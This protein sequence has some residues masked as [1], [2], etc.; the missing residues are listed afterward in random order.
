M[1]FAFRDWVRDK[2]QSLAAYLI[3]RGQLEPDCKSALDALAA[4]YEKDI[5]Q[6]AE[7]AVVATLG[8]HDRVLAELEGNLDPDARSL[9]SLLTT[10]AFPADDPLCGS[11]VDASDA[12]KSYKPRACAQ[13]GGRFRILRFHAEGA[14]GAIYVARDEELNRDVA[15]KQIKDEPAYDP[16]A[17]VRFVR[18]AEITGRLEH[19]G[20]VPV[21]GLGEYADG[22]PEYAMRFIE[23][24]SLRTAIKR[25]HA[26]GVDSAVDPASR[27]LALPNLVRR[28]LDV[29]NA[30]SYA[31]NRGIVHR[32]IKPSNIMLGPFGETLVV[33]WGLAKPIGR[34]EEAADELETTLRPS[35][36]DGEGSPTVGA[37]GTPNYMS[38]EQ[39]AGTN[40]QVSFGSDIYGLG[41]TLY[42]LL[43]GVAPFQGESD[44]PLAIL[45]RVRSGGFRKP[46]ELDPAVPPALEAVCLKAM[47]LEPEHRYKTT[48]ALAQDIE[49]WLADAPVSVYREPPLV[50][51]GRWVRRH[52]PLVAAVA[53]LVVCVVVALCVDVVHSRPRARGGR[54][55]FR[56]GP[57]GG[58]SGAY[59]DRGRTAGGCPA[60][61][62][63]AASSGKG[64]RRCSTSTFSASDRTTRPSFA[65]RL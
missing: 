30:V 65:T 3:E 6:N 39:A 24:E 4:L 8:R 31:H 14:L 45:A 9:V 1:V 62:G 37:I 27:A 23:G 2:N 44:D 53:V 41:A 52:K 33:D 48:R 13:S 43:T 47:A 18:E 15:L 50:R 7:R 38:P 42:C 16:N 26:G 10:L 57:R 63:A 25:H 32:D 36:R 46:R 29:C 49:R 60:S 12:T 17:R 55:Q 19:P 20:I 59:R 61:G 11:T 5:G 34:P 22:R 54:G 40:D 58:E 56:H 28:F 51:L 35:G 64:Q 21:Y